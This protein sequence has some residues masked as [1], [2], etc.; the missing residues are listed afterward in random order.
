MKK[1]PDPKVVLKSSTADLLS[2]SSWEVAEV[3]LSRE[4]EGRSIVSEV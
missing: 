1:V 3:P 2:V 4:E